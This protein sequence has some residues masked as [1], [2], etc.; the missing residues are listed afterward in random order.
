MA[1]ANIVIHD[2]IDLLLANGA[3]INQQ[4]YQ[5]KTA[6]HYAIQNAPQTAIEQNND[7]LEADD[8]K[9]IKPSF[10]STINAVS[11]RY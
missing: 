9:S 8:S 2:S 1:K 7:E 10:S 4:D 3:T 5:G 6:L 11:A